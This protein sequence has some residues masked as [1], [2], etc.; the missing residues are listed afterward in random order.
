VNVTVQDI[1]KT[2][3]GTGLLTT[4]VIWWLNR[5]KQRKEMQAIL[6]DSTSK[7]IAGLN[8]YIITLDNRINH[9]EKLIQKLQEHE[10][11]N[12]EVIKA[13]KKDNEE[14]K[15]KHSVIEKEITILKKI[16]GI[17]PAVWQRC[18]VYVIDDDPD[19]LD[20]FAHKLGANTVIDY[21]GFTNIDTFLVEVKL[22]YPEYV[23]IDYRLNDGKTANDVLE[24]MEYEPE[25]FI[26]S[27]VA[28]FEARIRGQKNIHFFAKDD[29]YVYKISEQILKHISERQ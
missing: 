16:S 9:Q 8:E 1:L 20:I 25:V 7:I 10:E 23:I 12:L 29:F 26:I 5:P 17:K 6:I 15:Y 4:F 13:I 14:L 3:I 18:K 2:L 11:E 28:G 27:G 22:E 21:R 19:E 24:A